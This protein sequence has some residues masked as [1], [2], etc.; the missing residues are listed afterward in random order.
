MPEPASSSASGVFGRSPSRPDVSAGQALAGAALALL[1][2]VYP[3]CV[4]RLLEAW[5]V[6]AVSVALLAVGGASLLARRRFAEASGL[7]AGTGLAFLAL[8]AL[9]ALT[10]ARLFLLFVPAAVY[11]VACAVF[12]RSLAGGSSLIER[13]ARLLQPRAPDFI[14]PYCRKVTTAWAVFFALA[15]GITAALAA[16]APLA[17]WHAFTTWTLWALACAFMAVEY[18]VRKAWFRYYLG[19]PLDRLWAAALPAEN[20]PQGRRS[21][22]YIRRARE[23]MERGHA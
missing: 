17:W 19:G 16:W 11:L 3:W 1:A 9:S 8:P 15:A 7:P 20:T 14:R 2:V 12:G 4:G 6:R 22:E 21:M 13:G 18:A 5:G 23:E 10:G